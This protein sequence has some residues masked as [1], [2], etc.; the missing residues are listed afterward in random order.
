MDSQAD[1]LA[2]GAMLVLMKWHQLHNNLELQVYYLAQHEKELV[3]STGDL[4][5]E[6]SRITVTQEE[7]A[8]ISS[9]YTHYQHMH[10]DKELC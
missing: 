5:R 10:K 8:V 9:F 6:Q 2:W 7:E 4:R 1:T 3:V